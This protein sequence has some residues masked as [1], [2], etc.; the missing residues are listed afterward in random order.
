MNWKQ[1]QARSVVDRRLSIVLTCSLFLISLLI[2][3]VPVIAQ[4]PAYGA[5]IVVDGDPAEWDLTNDFFADMYNAGN[6]NPDWPGFAI[7]SKLYLRYDCSAS[8]LY[9]LV[10]DVAE[11]GLMPDESPGDAW[12]KIYDIGWPNNLLINGNGEGN[13][14]PRGFE[15]VYETPGD[16][17]TPLLGFEAYAQLDEGIY[18]AFEA[19]LNISG[20]TSSTGRENQGHAIPL[21]IE[22][23]TV[24]AD[25]QPLSFDLKQ[26]YPNPFNPATTI[27]FSLE[28]TA[29]ATLIV[30]D[31][32]GRQVA[33]L[34]DGMR[35]AG[36]HS[37]VFNAV[38]LSS[39]VYF[40]RLEAEDLILT[41]KLV[42]IK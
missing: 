40:Y 36:P 28:Q 20:N 7:L 42:L 39:G 5:G 21:F 12:I 1:K 30:Y 22:C 19:H 18:D 2:T 17:N 6:P 11:D 41:R 10:L 13:T 23:I 29:A 25:E 8:N 3:P 27:E 38:D 9:A 35:E 37:V 15:W 34:V 4:H 24:D 26:N 14:S 33:R 16:D 32:T 31:L